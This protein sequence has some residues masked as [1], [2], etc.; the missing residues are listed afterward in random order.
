MEKVKVTKIQKAAFDD[1]KRRY[2]GE[3]NLLQSLFAEYSY[4]IDQ[5]PGLTEITE[6]QAAA[7]CYFPELVEEEQTPEEI[8]KEKYEEKWQKYKE[9]DY[10]SYEESAL[11]GFANGVL[12]VLNT[13][14]VKIEGVN[15]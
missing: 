11:L 12:F 2:C 14:G 1:F 15:D 8:I 4:W 10:N 13:Q 3:T 9:A 6:E 7:M 5:L